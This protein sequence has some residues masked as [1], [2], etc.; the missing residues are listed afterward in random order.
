[1]NKTVDYYK[2]KHYAT[3][4]HMQEKSLETKIVSIV[5]EQAHKKQLEVTNQFM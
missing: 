2:E 1:M 5:I 3:M 4:Y